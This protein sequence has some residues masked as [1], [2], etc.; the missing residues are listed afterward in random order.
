MQGGRNIG[1][2][3]PLSQWLA[4][5]YDKIE[6]ALGH[7]ICYALRLSDIKTINYAIPVVFSP[8]DEGEI[9]FE[10]HFI[11]DPNYRGLA[12]VV[13][14]WVTVITCDVATYG[15]GT[16]FIC[17]PIGMVT[18]FAMDRWVAPKIAPKLYDLICK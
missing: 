12:P 11:H 8:C 18:E 3:K 6:A 16:F 4:G 5:V 1:D 14:Y 17:S 9:E 10:L 13:T 15:A 7:E 2:F